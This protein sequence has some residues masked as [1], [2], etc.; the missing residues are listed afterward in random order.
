ML[1]NFPETVNLTLSGDGIWH[2][3]HQ[4]SI[5]LSLCLEKG[6]E[7]L[8]SWQYGC[9]MSFLSLKRF[10]FYSC[11]LKIADFVLYYI[12]HIFMFEITKFNPANFF[13][14]YQPQTIS[15][16]CVCQIIPTNSKLSRLSEKFSIFIIS[17]LYDVKIRTS[18]PFS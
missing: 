6:C 5:W 7:V 15:K 13:G 8:W 3:T 18:Q 14:F 10:L 11:R 16:F 2:T 4:L 17:I 1:F 9:I 12:C